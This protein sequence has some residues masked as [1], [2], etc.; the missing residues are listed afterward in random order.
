[1]ANDTEKTARLSLRQLMLPQN[2]RTLFYGFSYLRQLVD[3][4]YCADSTISWR[5]LD[6][7]H[8]AAYEQLGTHSTYDQK[9]RHHGA[10]IE[11]SAGI[12][13]FYTHGRV[14]WMPPLVLPTE[15][16]SRR[17]NATA[18]LVMNVEDLQ[19]SAGTR[20]KLPAF[21]ERHG[22]FDLIFFQRPHADCFFVYLETL[23]ARW[24]N[25]SRYACVDLGVCGVGDRAKL[26]RDKQIWDL[27]RLRARVA[28]FEV[29]PWGTRVKDVP[30]ADA[31][32]LAA[33]N[34]AVQARPCSMMR[35]DPT[36]FGHQCRGSGITLA[37]RELVR[38]AETT[39]SSTRGVRASGVV[40][41][42]LGE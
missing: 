8:V 25:Q 1:M 36:S 23:L 22:P 34:E 28:A 20:T 29:E 11:P 38:L 32:H 19:H 5:F 41:D 40:H 3:E 12:E 15:W 27:L 4:L 9:W 18:V 42:A 10:A 14:K 31:A 35:C 17:Q 26:A 30:F 7:A 6:G 16:H 13:V 37:A 21:L 24:K 39:T 33:P 2:S